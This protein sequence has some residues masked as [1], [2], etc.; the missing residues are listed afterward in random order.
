MYDHDK[1]R[2]MAT[3]STAKI[4]AVTIRGRTHCD[5]MQEVTAS[6]EKASPFLMFR[7]EVERRRIFHFS[8]GLKSAAISAFQVCKYVCNQCLVFVALFSQKWSFWALKT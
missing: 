7:N 8:F 2:K 5:G 1:R 3:T 4:K 6:D